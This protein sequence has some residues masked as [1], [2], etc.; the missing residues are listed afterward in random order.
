[1]NIVEMRNIVK[2]FPGVLANDRVSLE[3]CQGEIH[4]LLGENGA[5][6]STLMNILYGLYRPDAGDILFRGQKVDIPTPHQAID[7]GI[8]MVH[9]HFMLVP[10]LTVT[11]NLV[12]GAEPLKGPFLDLRSAVAK[13]QAISSEYGLKVDP[14]ARIQDI[15]VGMQQRVEIL[16]A[17]YRGAEVLI[18]DEPT[19]VLTPREIDDLHR[20]LE[21]LRSNG[22]TIII[23]THKLREVQ[24]FSDRVTVIR[25]GRNVATVNSKEVSESVLANMMVGRE[26]ILRVEKQAREPGRVVLQLEAIEAR[27]Y[28]GLPALQGVSLT[29]RAGEIVGVAGVEGNGQTELVEVLTGLRQPAAGSATFDGHKIKGYEPCR[30]L[31]LGMGHIPED[32]QKRGLVLDFAV[33]EN[34]ILGFEDG[35]SF[36]RGLLLDYGR[37]DRFARD[38]IQNYGIRAPSP[39]VTVR[40]LSGGNQQ[41][42]IIAREMA[43]RP[44]LL[45][46]AQPTRGLDVGAIEFVHQQLLSQ[47]AAGA[48]ILLVSYELDEIMNLSDRIVVLYGGR[49]VATFNA[50]QVSVEELGL[51]MGGAMART[52]QEGGEH[53]QELD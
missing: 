21:S 50:G 47:R 22:R 53:G 52:Q 11:E 31:D 13:V 7:L 17:L 4:A 48:A 20:V 25:D 23:I 5:G 12:L 32:R 39:K 43:R 49:I 36:S 16:K 40:T 9:Q 51:L 29:V 19:A 1:M 10:P 46:A 15:S 33:T 6:K 35:K 14:L 27:N 3:V 45:V 24:Q 41:K 18:L 2:R 26:V 34:L 44:K 30:L 38:L 42:V 8:G 28:R 37:I